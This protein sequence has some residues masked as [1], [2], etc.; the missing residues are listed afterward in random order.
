MDLALFNKVILDD[1]IN[2][3]TTY[4]PTPISDQSKE[5]EGQLLAY[6]TVISQ[7]GDESQPEFAEVYPRQSVSSPDKLKAPSVSPNYSPASDQVL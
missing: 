2:D 1:I 7:Y 3:I 5:E 6:Q 4:L